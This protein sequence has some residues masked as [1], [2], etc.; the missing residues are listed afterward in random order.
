MAASASASRRPWSSAGDGALLDDLLVAAL[1]RAVALADVDAVAVAVDDDLDLDVA[2][3]L[4]PLLEVQRVVA[5]G[6]QCLRAT[7]GHRLLQLALRADHAH[8]LAAAAGRRLDQHRVA[9]LL[10]LR[11]AVRVVAQHARAGDRRQ[12]VARQQRPR[13]GLGAEALE[14]LGRRADEG[15]PVGTGHL[16]K[17]VVLGQEAVTG[18]DRI[19]AG[20]QR[21]G[22][23]R[24]RREVAPARLGRTDADRLVGELN[25]ARIAICLAVGDDRGDVHAPAGAQDAQRDLASVGDQDLAKHQPPS[26]PARRARSAGRTRPPGPARP[27]ARRASPSIV[28]TTSWRTPSTSTW[29]IRSPLLIAEPTLTPSRGAK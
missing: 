21:G 13:P 10:G 5:E 11:H 26:A 16:G 7:H 12:A 1:D 24:R 8:A 22:Q 9:D 23:Q 19:A 25:G 29:P 6:R 14:H 17:G 15:Q 20:H 28:A 3:F 18:V 4:E 27:R 2:V